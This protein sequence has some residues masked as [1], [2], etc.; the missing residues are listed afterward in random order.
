ML[1]GFREPSGQM[2]IGNFDLPDLF[3]VA[4]GFDFPGDRFDGP[5]QPQMQAPL[6][7]FRTDHPKAVMI[8]VATKARMK[9]SIAMKTAGR[10]T[11]VTNQ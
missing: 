6:S 3:C 11:W 9:N 8:A 7:A 1:D 10:M 2:S 4:E 5:G